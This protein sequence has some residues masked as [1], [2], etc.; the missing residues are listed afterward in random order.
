V[1]PLTR[2]LAGWRATFDRRTLEGEPIT[3][4]ERRVV[5]LARAT[6]FFASGL[7]G[8]VGFG[9]VQTRP[10]AVRVESAQGVQTI[11]I[12]DVTRLVIAA[13]AVSSLLLSLALHLALRKSQ[14]R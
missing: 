8:R 10:L 4:A 6:S 14:R 5:P 1:A 11:P 12:H 13:V 9:A 2:E 3:A 7:G